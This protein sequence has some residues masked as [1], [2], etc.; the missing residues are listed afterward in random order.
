MQR[1]L[2]GPTALLI[3]PPALPCPL[4][5]CDS[6]SDT[7]RLVAYQAVPLLVGIVAGPGAAGG[8]GAASGGAG[9]GGAAG[10]SSS[11]DGARQAAARA[12]SNLVCC[13]V[14]TQVPLPPSSRMPACTPLRPLHSRRP[15]VQWR[16]TPCRCTQKPQCLQRWVPP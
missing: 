3:R 9:G 12:I 2:A 16:I 6:L 15:R 4:Q 10:A 13:D 8:P 7:L 14:T 5:V 11:S 1:L